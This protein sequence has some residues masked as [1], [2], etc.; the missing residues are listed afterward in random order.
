MEIDPEVILIIVL[1]CAVLYM[2]NECRCQNSCDNF[3]V[4]APSFGEDIVKSMRGIV[5]G[6]EDV[7]PNIAK[8][9]NNPARLD[10]GAGGQV[11]FEKTDWRTGRQ[12]SESKAREN[13]AMEDAEV[14]KIVSDELRESEK[15]VIYLAKTPKTTTNEIEAAIR[16]ARDALTDMLWETNLSELKKL[17][18]VYGVNPTYLEKVDKMTNK[19]KAK[20]K[21]I[22]LIAGRYKR[23]VWEPILQSFPFR[24]NLN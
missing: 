14:M 5:F 17:A 11:D 7:D 19:Q 12:T 3:Y 10:T 2:T 16:N 15:Y 23:Y 13:E 24:I 22:E 9:M 8:M 6:D 20:S 18:N 1:V 4:G 21:I